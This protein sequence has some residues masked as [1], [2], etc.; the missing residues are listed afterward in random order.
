MN[1]HCHYRDSYWYGG[2]ISAIGYI[3]QFSSYGFN[4]VTSSIINARAYRVF[5]Y[6]NSFQGG[7]SI[8]TS[9]YHFWENLAN[10]GFNDK[11]SSAASGN[12]Y[13]TCP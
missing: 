9:G 4:D 11:I 7:A 8:C 5:S 6:Q 10:I 3:N 13:A 12:T 1:R 2:H